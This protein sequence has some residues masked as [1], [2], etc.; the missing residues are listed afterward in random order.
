M[1]RTMSPPVATLQYATPVPDQSVAS[2]YRR[3]TN[4]H[5]VPKSIEITRSGL[6]I[7]KVELRVTKMRRIALPEYNTWEPNGFRFVIVTSGAPAI[8]TK[9]F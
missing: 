9:V 8:T 4:S 7:L 1:C 6:L 5:V 3:E 2:M